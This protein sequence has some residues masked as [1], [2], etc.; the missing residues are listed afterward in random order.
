MKQKTNRDALWGL[1]VYDLL[2]KINDG[3]MKIDGGDVC[4]LDALNGHYAHSPHCI[5]PWVNPI[6]AGNCDKCILEYLDK[7][8]KA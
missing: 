8:A 4:V 7:E 6:E 3:L 5:R 1:C 2:C